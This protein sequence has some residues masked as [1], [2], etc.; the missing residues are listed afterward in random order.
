MIRAAT[1]SLI[2]IIDLKN[3]LIYSEIAIRSIDSIEMEFCVISYIHGLRKL[4]KKN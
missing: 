3:R 2:K 4:E 1:F